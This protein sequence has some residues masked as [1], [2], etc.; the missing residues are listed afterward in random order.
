MPATTELSRTKERP[1]TR[2]EQTRN[3]QV[4]HPNVDILELPEELLVIADV[5]GAR[6]D[7]IDVRFENGT[8]TIHARIEPRQNDET[9]YLVREY[10]VGD[11]HRSFEVSEWIDAQRISA[12]IANG[13]LTLHLP[14]SEEARP[15]KIPVR[16]G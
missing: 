14:K 12:E 6:R 10:G 1:A 11:F 9:A 16:A 8:L 3:G 5:P 15:R 13:V 4:Y 7:G 2:A